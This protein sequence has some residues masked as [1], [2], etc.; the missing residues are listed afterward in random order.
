MINTNLLNYEFKLDI[1]MYHNYKR[2]MY[3]CMQT[4][5][6]IPVGLIILVLHLWFI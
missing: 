4:Y 3:F 1:K 2:H 5:A 6:Y